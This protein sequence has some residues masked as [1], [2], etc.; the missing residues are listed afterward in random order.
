MGAGQAQLLLRV[1]GDAPL[2]HLD[3]ALARQV[4]AG[5]RVVASHHRF[6]RALG[7]DAPAVNAGTGADVEHVVGGTDGVLVVFH[8]DH[9]VAQIAQMDQRLEQ[10]VVVT[11]VQADGGLV[12]DVH[13]AHQAGA[14]LARQANALGLAAGE[15]LG[16]ALQV[17]VVEADV[18]QELEPGVYLV[19]H[20]L[21]DLALAPRQG[22]ALEVVPGLADGQLHDLRQ[23]MLVDED[24]AGFL[25]QA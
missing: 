3:A 9:G 7:D 15:G 12:E 22:Q 18:D 2:G 19:D 4:L 5:E 8:H 20:L 10:A 1:A 25:A 24:V 6:R 21:G 14:D 16:A 11:L 17:E 13:H 23:G